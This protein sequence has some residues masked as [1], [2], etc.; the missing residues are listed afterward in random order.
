[1]PSTERKAANM[2][3]DDGNDDKE[4]PILRKLELLRGASSQK[5]RKAGGAGSFAELLSGLGDGGGGGGGGGGRGA[6]LDL[7]GAIKAAK[8]TVVQVQKRSGEAGGD[9][10]CAAVGDEGRGGRGNLATSSSAPGSKKQKKVHSLPMDWDLKKVGCS[11]WLLLAVLKSHTHTH[12]RGLLASG[13]VPQ[14]TRR[15]L[16]DGPH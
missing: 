9:G 2:A 10:S 3:D 11:R 15:R 8:N 13:S 1:M 14:P 5:R 16:P 12:T 4:D 7:R 6:G